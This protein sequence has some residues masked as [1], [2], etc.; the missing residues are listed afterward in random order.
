MNNAQIIEC[1]KELG[2]DFNE[3]DAED[4]LTTATWAYETVW[5]AVTDYLNAY[6]T[7]ADFDTD[8]HQQIKTKWDAIK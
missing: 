8:K 1:A 5:E 2:F 3:V 7:C 6:E 4:V